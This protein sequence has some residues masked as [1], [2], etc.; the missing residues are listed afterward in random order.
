MIRR[1]ILSIFLMTALAPVLA[2][3]HAAAQS[4]RLPPDPLVHPL[5]MPTPEAASAFARQRSAAKKRP[6]AKRQRPDRKVVSVEVA[7]CA[8]FV[9]GRCIGRD[10]DP[11]VRFM[12]RHDARMY[13]D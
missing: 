10:P 3:S 9:R 8:A 6:A 12:I 1:G 2:A 11:T 4:T 7:P 13:D 5:I